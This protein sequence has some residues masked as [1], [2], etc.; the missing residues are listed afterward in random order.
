MPATVLVT[1]GTG[2]IGLALV[3]QLLIQGNNVH[4]TV[5]DLKNG[6]KCRPLLELQSKFPGKLELFEA[7]LLKPQSFDASMKS[8]TVVH[9]V[10]SPF[11]LPEKIKDGENEIIKPALEG[12]RNVLESVNRTETVT[13]VVLTSSSGAC[14]GDYIDCHRM[15]DH[16]V[17]EEYFNT[18]S[19]VTWQ[20]YHYSKVL[21]E[22]E[23]WKI[24]KAQSRWTM[25][26]ILP[27]L[28][29]GPSIS[30][31]SE[32]GSLFLLDEILKG[33]FFF[34]APDFGFIV[35]DVRE[36]VQ[37]HI[38]AAEKPNA[39]GRYLISQSCMW[40]FLDIS[41]ELRKYK[42]KWY[43][44]THQIPTFVVRMLGPLFFGLTQEYIT[45]NVGVKFRAGNQRS[46]DE[47]GIEYRPMEE[48][49]AAHYQ[50]WVA[51]NK[52]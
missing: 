6:N 39:S 35:V 41:K 10:A 29:L 19:S 7:D 43:I 46:I 25:V 31:G 44:P 30:D 1:G 26:A 18:T 23:A 28:V 42:P 11:R 51:A 49:I 2:Y 24:C 5:R 17:T 36:V 9:H 14:Y 37:A 27:S 15:K 8:C 32:S 13:R 40:T 4:T 48:T 47:L 38:A 20:P 50:Q 16:T 52:K 22:K 33:Y 12:T 34:G 21:A 45:K 3:Q